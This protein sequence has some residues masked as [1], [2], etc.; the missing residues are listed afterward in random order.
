[1]L[2]REGVVLSGVSVGTSGAG[3]SGDKGSK[4]RQGARQ[5]GVATVQPA[6]IDRTPGPG[7]VSG[8]ALDLFV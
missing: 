5:S 6:R 2:Q 8:G 1:M 7:R 3:E 4:S